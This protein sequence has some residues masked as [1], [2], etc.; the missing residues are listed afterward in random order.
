MAQTCSPCRQRK[1]CDGLFPQCSQC[2][3]ARK[4]L[5]CEYGSPCLPASYK[6]PGL[7]KGEACFP[8]RKKKKRCDG[9]RPSCATC[10]VAGKESECQYEEVIT[11]D[12]ARV[13]QQNNQRLQEENQGLQ[14]ENKILQLQIERLQQQLAGIQSVTDSTSVQSTASHFPPQA[15]IPTVA[16]GWSGCEVPSYWNL[17][18]STVPSPA[19]I[20]VFPAQFSVQSGIDPFLEHDII[21]PTIDKP[22]LPDALPIDEKALATYRETF[23]EHHDQLGLCLRPAK[24]DAMRRGDLSGQVVDPVLVL[25][26]QLAGCRLWREHRRWPVDRPVEHIL[27]GWVS[28]A[29]SI[30]N[31][32]VARL[33]VHTVLAIHFLIKLDMQEG[34]LQLD[35]AAKLGVSNQYAFLSPPIAGPDSSHD[36]LA[37]HVGALCQ[38]VYLDKAANIVLGTKPMLPDRFERGYEDL[39]HVLP[40]S[41]AKNQFPVLRARSIGLLQRARQLAFEYKAAKRNQGQDQRAA[42][43]Q[44]DCAQVH[45]A[46]RAHIEGLSPLA[47]ALFTHGSRA[48]RLSV[49]LCM[50]ISMTASVELHAMQFNEM[51]QYR[52]QCVDTIWEIVRL[53]QGFRDGDYIYLD[54][55]LGSCW[56]TVSAVLNNQRWMSLVTCTPMHWQSAMTIMIESGEKLNRTLPFMGTSVEAMKIAAGHDSSISVS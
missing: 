3:K 55:I 6:G 23:I 42:V 52:Q 8:C 48:N 19:E 4:P 39:L 28:Q 51:D 54:P 12:E 30:T 44:H 29:L 45:A 53:T 2:T 18:G 13:L 5:K 15:V 25:V 7:N 40:P 43:F 14:S 49:K 24:V 38:L 41:I 36:D 35:E 34:A 50:I 26:A 20:L 27:F 10:T 16:Q 37:E 22:L 47:Q 56:M 46:V 32:L 33:Q 9:R 31:C 21:S 11:R 1:K 17:D